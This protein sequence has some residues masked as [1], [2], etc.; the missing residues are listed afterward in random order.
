MYD[1]MGNPRIHLKAYLDLLVG[2]EQGNKL[3]MRLFVR[4]L[5][6]LALMWY[7][8]QDATIMP[9]PSHN[10]AV[11]PQFPNQVPPHGQVTAGSRFVA[12]NFSLS[13][14]ARRTY[15]I[16]GQSTKNDFVKKGH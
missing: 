13:V 14:S 5:T 11:C 15:D 6:R 1:G 16:D 8:K 4:M 2:M 9:M 7:A 12:P 3:K 10:Q